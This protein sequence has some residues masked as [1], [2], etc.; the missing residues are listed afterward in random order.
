MKPGWPTRVFGPITPTYRVDALDVDRTRLTGAM[1]LPPLGGLL[2]RARRYLL[3]W[4]D[5]VMMI[6][7]LH[8]LAA[9]A[10]HGTAD[11]QARP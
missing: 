11:A 6:K 5:L 1:W 7:Q 3:A 8:T 2:S 4:G 10:E 9:L